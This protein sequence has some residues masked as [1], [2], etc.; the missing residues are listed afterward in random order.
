MKPGHLLMSALHREK[1][2]SLANKSLGVA[3]IGAGGQGARRAQAVRLANGWHLEGIFDSD[4]IR[5]REAAEK[6][7]CHCFESVDDAINS[8][9]VDVV[10]IATPPGSHDELI[11]K[12]LENGRHVLCE[13]PL[14]IN[15]TLA[16]QYLHLARCRQLQLATGFNHRFF[17]PVLD[18]KNLVKDQAIGNVLAIRGHIGEQPPAAILDGWLGNPLI[19]GG[20][21]LT[22]NG[23][24]L[25]DLARVLMNNA[26]LKDT[27]VFERMTGRSGIENHCEFI[28]TDE[29]GLNAHLTTSWKTPDAKYLMLEVRGELGVI[30][31]SAFPWRLTIERPGQKMLTKK[32]LI[33]RMAMKAM[34]RWAEGLE[35]SLIRELKSLRQSILT[36]DHP[37]SFHATGHDGLATAHIINRI[38]NESEN[39]VK[40]ISQSNLSRQIA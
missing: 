12:A 26:Q 34:S 17:K 31:I 3:V 21:V 18:L 32:Y 30:S 7:K 8:A 15:P 27:I 23:S 9:N 24:H 2:Q 37:A 25:I 6:W 40:T 28:L 33:D 10:M 19:S 14:T 39:M 5:S 16:E 35:L 13:K 22:D 36:P 20:G 1:K 38:R 4:M 11:I 29:N